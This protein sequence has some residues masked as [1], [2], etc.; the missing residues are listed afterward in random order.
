MAN[1]IRK[2]QAVV[3]LVINGRAAETSIKGIQKA[4]FET[5]KLLRNMSKA[6]DPVAY[7]KMRQE[8]LK[9]KAVQS[10][11]NS[12][13]RE[14]KNAL[15]NVT[16]ELKQGESGW[17]KFKK[18]INEIAF[19]TAGGNLIVAGASAALSAIK[20][21][22][23]GAK[24]EYQKYDEAA[25]SLQSATL[26]TDQVLQQ[27]KKNAMDLNGEMGFT[28]EDYLKAATKIGS[29][30]SELADSAEAMDLMVEKSMLF[31][32]AGKLDLPEA[33]E[34]LAMMLNQFSKDASEAGHF[35]DVLAQGFALGAAE[36]PQM[37]G[38]MKY[39]G[40]AANSMNISFGETNASIQMLVKNGLTAEMAGTQLRAIL[41]K[42]GSGADETN[43]KVVGL[44]KALENLAKK[45]LTTKQMAELFNAENI[46]GANILLN[47]I[48]TLEKW[49]K[50]IEESGAA[51]KMAAINMST[52]EQAEKDFGVVTT[53]I[54]VTV[55]EKLSGAF[56][57]A[58]EWCTNLLKTFKEVVKNSDGVIEAFAGIFNVI[59]DLL[60]SL[61]DLILTLEGYNEG[62][63]F[64]IDVTKGVGVAL[65]IVA[66]AFMAVVNEVTALVGTFDVLIN[67]G[68]KVMNFFGADFKINP[69][70]TLENV[71][72]K[73]QKNIDKITGWFTP[74]KAPE[75][76]IP[77]GGY[78]G[79]GNWW[80]NISTGNYS[81]ETVVSDNPPKNPDRTGNGRGKAK[82]EVDEFKSLKAELERLR[83]EIAL[84]AMKANEREIAQVVFKYDKMRDQAQKNK[85]LILQINDLEKRELAQLEEKQTKK[86]AEEADKRKADAIKKLHEEI[87]EREKLAEEARQKQAEGEKALAQF[88][89]SVK[90]VKRR[91]IKSKISQEAEQA[92]IQA[93]QEQMEKAKA[94]IKEQFDKAIAAAPDELRGKLAQ[95]YGN[96]LLDIEQEF[97]DAS[98]AIHLDYVMRRIESYGKLA[99]NISDIMTSFMEISGSNATEFAE[100]QKMAALIQI[101]VDTASAI[102]SV[103]KDGAIVGVTPVEKLVTITG[104]IAM[105]LAN[106][107]KAKQVL[108]QAGKLE[109]PQLQR[110]P[111]RETGGST[112]LLSLYMDNSGNPQGY[113][114]RPTLF[115]LGAR[116]WMGGEGSKQEYVFS[117]AM[118]QNPV[119]ARFAAMAETLRTSGYDFTRRADMAPGPQ[120]QAGGAELL[121]AME[122]L[123]AETR[124]HTAAV[125]GFAQ[126]PW[127]THRLTDVLE[128]DEQ[129]KRD[130]RA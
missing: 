125:E 87:V 84:D 7:E 66:G 91:R 116:S 76:P 6:A 124:R 29:A 78:S 118:L 83:E 73:R 74:P 98:D 96:I 92:D 25:A 10:E 108:S 115:N 38:A 20:N 9:L 34:A 65:K 22:V 12:E 23:G 31:A 27:L 56:Q 71:G 62:S 99:T 21:F 19:G 11:L 100:F 57:K 32:R 67:S 107:A 53:D 93:A 90:D 2:E 104:G 17:S 43:P 127:S 110:M 26:M 13:L 18:N 40:V 95:T 117:Y 24:E 59:G 50:K 109:K 28:A 36:L 88:N 48:P 60:G 126:K 68:K 121:S 54:L 37:V 46:A 106:I 75:K 49:T 15:D 97:Y 4:T 101:T 82:K 3:D 119:M 5:E 30:K 55:G 85:G 105:V 77:T 14:S 44:E 123:I 89:D 33:G 1:P 113:I 45:N 120:Q 80:E 79:A 111:G 41:L 58:Y 122:L 39:A 103:I 129:I 51:E 94:Q 86:A 63:T 16:K 112:D 81:G 128:L 130:A 61:K 70:A 72:N 52:L 47:N 64:V 42:L 35:V 69:L 114:N 102:G 8:L